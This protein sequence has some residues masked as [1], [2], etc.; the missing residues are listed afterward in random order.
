MDIS[1]ELQS[2]QKK[3]TYDRNL[4]SVVKDFKFIP[5]IYLKW[6]KITDE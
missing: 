4:L 2:K 5:Y 1:P 3:S 6:E